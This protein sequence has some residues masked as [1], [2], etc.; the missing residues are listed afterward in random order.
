MKRTTLPALALPLLAVATLSGCGGGSPAPSAS[1][2][3]APAP[4]ALAACVTGH[5]WTLDVADAASQS[6]AH[7]Q[8]IGLPVTALVGSGTQTMQWD[9]NGHVDVETALTYDITITED[10]DNVLV[11]SQAHHGPATGT[12]TIQGT[13]ALPT[14]WD[15]SGYSVTST[16]TKNGEPL[17]SSPMDFPD[18]ELPGV[19][20][21]LT[22][23][24][25][26]LTTL[27]SDGF[28][29]YRWTRD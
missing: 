26:T 15:A 6:L 5:T 13:Q 17:G 18:S 22:C 16:G 9:A 20:L 23:S 14:G 8:G 25:N 29:N 11:V 27:A 10:A 7:F 21:A 24:G 28:V 1:A 3:S 4:S 12:F 2:P 19:K